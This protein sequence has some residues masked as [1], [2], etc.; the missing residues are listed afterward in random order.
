MTGYY[1]ATAQ[2]LVFGMATGQCPSG[3]TTCLDLELDTGLM[4]SPFQNVDF[5]SGQDAMGDYCNSGNQNLGLFDRRNR[6]LASTGGF[7]RAVPTPFTATQLLPLSVLNGYRRRLR[8]LST[9]ASQ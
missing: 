1:D 4:N 5:I 9:H 6:S 3:T 2:R 8:R 7:L